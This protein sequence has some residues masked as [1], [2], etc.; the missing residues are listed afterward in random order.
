MGH[1][2]HGGVQEESSGFEGQM[3]ECSAANATF[4]RLELG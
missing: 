3:R 1:I 2:W 4:D